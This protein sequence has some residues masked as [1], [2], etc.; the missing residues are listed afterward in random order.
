MHEHVIATLPAQ[1]LA[2]Q[3]TAMLEQCY[4]IAFYP[5]DI[6]VREQQLAHTRPLAASD[7]S[8]ARVRHSHQLTVRP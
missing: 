2:V 7:A 3:L 1:L 4:V 6:V 8:A 5:S